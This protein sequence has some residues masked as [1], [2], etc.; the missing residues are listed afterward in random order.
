MILLDTGFLIALFRRGDEYHT[1]A[2]ELQI[3]LDASGESLLF[4]EC[5]LAEFASYIRRSDGAQRAA[6]ASL[7]LLELKRGSL[8]FPTELEVRNA[9]A[10]LK[11]FSFSSYAD[12]LL[13]ALA[14]SRGIRKIASFDSDF[15]R[16]RGI[17]RLQ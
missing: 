11:K 16:V 2:S 5:V 15:D 8:V 4:P 1:R 9:F 7:A 3:Q 17:T 13:V 6:E 10:V 12:A 14:D